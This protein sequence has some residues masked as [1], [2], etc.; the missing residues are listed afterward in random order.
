M[1]DWSSDVC[2]SDL[3]LGVDRVDRPGRGLR[4]CELAVALAVVVVDL[5]GHAVHVDLDVRRAGVAISERRSGLQGGLEH[6]GLERR[7]RLTTRSAALAASHE[8]NL[9]GVEVPSADMEI[10]RAHV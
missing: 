10:G 9:Q 4:Q 2:S 6:E 3:H 8:V 1:M 7:A 5:E